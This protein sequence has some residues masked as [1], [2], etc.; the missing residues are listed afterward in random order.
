MKLATLTSSQASALVDELRA[1]AELPAGANPRVLRRAK[2]IRFQLQ[3]QASISPSAIEKADEVYG[4][5][6]I[7]LHDHRWRAEHSLDDLRKRIKSS[8]ERLRA[9][10]GLTSRPLA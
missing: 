8:C 1:M 5:L 10:L 7:L 9:H 4:E 2:E 6:V 3:G